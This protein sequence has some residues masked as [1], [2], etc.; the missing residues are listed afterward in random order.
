MG[1]ESGA[2]GEDVVVASSEGPVGGV[3]KPGGGM[4]G[5][6][7]TFKDFPGAGPPNKGGAIPGVGR[8]FTVTKSSRIP[9]PD[10]DVRRRPS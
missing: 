10:G 4:N 8:D 5:G 2:G 9:L 1:L 6:A 7:S 3:F